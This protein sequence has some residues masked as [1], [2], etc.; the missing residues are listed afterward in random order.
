MASKRKMR[1]MK[2]FRVVTTLTVAFEL[3][4]YDEDEVTDQASAISWGIAEG[5]SQGADV[6][7]VQVVE[8]LS[9]KDL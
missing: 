2:T 5:I 3:E 1:K 7:E 4:G 9:G 8:K 6:L